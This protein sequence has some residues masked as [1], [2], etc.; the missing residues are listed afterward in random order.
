MWERGGGQDE[1]E[2]EV[3]TKNDFYISSETKV[4]GGGGGGGGTDRAKETRIFF[5]L[6]VFFLYYF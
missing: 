5:R 1:R 2:R 3:E 4:E 6:F